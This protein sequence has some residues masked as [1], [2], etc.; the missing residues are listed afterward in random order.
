MWKDFLP[1]QPANSTLYLSYGDSLN[2]FTGRLNSSVANNVMNH[3]TVSSFVKNNQ[4]G[5][6]RT[7][8]GMSES[9]R[10]A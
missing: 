4:H 1:V 5:S 8:T 3:L 2:R 6:E 9:V 10:I 7:H